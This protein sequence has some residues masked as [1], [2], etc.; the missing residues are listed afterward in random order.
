MSSSTDLGPPQ[1]PAN[2]TDTKRG[3][4]PPPPPRLSPDFRNGDFL[5]RLLAATPPY[6]YN[7]PLVPQ[8]FFFSDMLKSFVQGNKPP[9]PP[10]TREPPALEFPTSIPAA[11]ESAPAKDLPGRPPHRRRKRTWREMSEPPR[12]MIDRKPP[13]VLDKPLELTNNNRSSSNEENNA[14]ISRQEG[15]PSRMI[16][17]S[18]E[19]TSP[20]NSAEASSPPTLPPPPPL[21][22]PSLPH[23]GMLP[24]PG[25]DFHAS[26]LNSTAE[27]MSNELIP[28]LPPFPPPMWYPGLYPGLNPN[29]PPQPPYGIDPLH[30]FIDLRVSGHIWDRKP[31]F[32]T[33][34]VQGSPTGLDC[35]V[36]KERR[37]SSPHGEVTSSRLTE[38]EQSPNS[39][40]RGPLNLVSPSCK[41]SLGL[42]LG[43][44][45]KHSKHT[46]AFSVPEPRPLMMTTKNLMGKKISSENRKKGPTTNYVLQNL[47]RIYE[48]MQEQQKDKNEGENVVEEKVSEEKKDGECKDLPALIGLELVVDYVKHEAKPGARRATPPASPS[49]SSPP[50]EAAPTQLAHSPQPERA[51]TASP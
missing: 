2:S 23:C 9:E 32:G 14:K 12:F 10:P 33:P 28:S 39:E 42:L 49:R 47:S 37:S 38:L 21:L 4:L 6:L 46:S 51:A 30:F 31:P 1:F 3:I 16:S 48:D 5:S 34:G 22:M 36:D 15:S 7:I 26:R 44:G 18:L 40:D 50:A 43:N 35:T 19:R 25:T 17:P 20:G 29:L 11:P 24:L 8:S 27:S 41:S 13:P 45:S